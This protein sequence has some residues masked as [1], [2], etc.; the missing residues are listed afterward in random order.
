MVEATERVKRI[1]ITGVAGFIGSHLAA[2]LLGEGYAVAGIDNFDPF[3]D[4]AVKRKNVSQLTGDRNFSFRE[5]DITHPGD[6]HAIPLTVDAVIHLAAKPGVFPSLEAPEAYIRTNV[7]GT[8]N[9][10][11]WMKASGVKKLVFAS[12]SSVYGNPSVLPFTEDLPTDCPVSPYAYT[13][14]SGELLNHTYHHL[15]GMDVVNLRLFSVYGPGQRPDLVVGKFM[16]LFAGQQPIP[17]YGNG[18]TVRDYTYI[19]DVV[20]GIRAALR[21]L[22]SGDNVFE[23]IN[24][25]GNRPVSLLELIHHLGRLFNAKPLIRYLPRRPGEVDVTYADTTKAASLLGYRPKVSIEEG[26]QKCVAAL[27]AGEG[28]TAPPGAAARLPRR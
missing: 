19:S 20:D 26:L 25:G 21:Y 2:A 15:Y 7:N 13:K 12:S 3:Y 17:V 9:V 11:N 28:R 1:L 24:L 8:L 5:A 27:S 4:V 22:L 23:S 14:K 6:L 16:G 10:L 18:G